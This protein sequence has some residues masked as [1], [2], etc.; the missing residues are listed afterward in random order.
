MLSSSTWL[1]QIVASS[2]AELSGMNDY[3]TVYDDFGFF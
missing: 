2:S 1:V 3:C